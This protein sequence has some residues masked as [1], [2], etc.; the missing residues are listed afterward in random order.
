MIRLRLLALP[1][2]A[3][4][5]ACDAALPANSPQA[6]LHPS[7]ETATREASA[8]A[9]LSALLQEAWDDS[10]REHPIRASTLGDRRWNSLW[11][12]V[13]KEGFERRHQ[14]DE[15][16]LAR[17]RALPR[18]SLSPQ[19][20]LNYDIFERSLSL[21]IEA[22]P[23]GLY[24]LILNPREGIQTRDVLTKTLRFET[25]K[26][27]ED[28]L[29][30]LKAFPAYTDQTIATLREGIRT[31]VVQARVVME[32]VPAQLDKQ[33]VPAEESGFFAPFRKFPG[34]VPAAERDRL[35][36]AAR[37][38]IDAAVVPSF[39]RLREFVV[40]EY[41][42]ACFEQVGAWQ[43]P[44]GAETYVYL[45]R[46]HTTTSLSPQQIH[47][48]GIAEVAR[49]RAEME[50][51]KAKVGF[52][53]SLSEFFTML[54]SDPR[55]FY[56]TKDELFAGYQAIAKRIDP[57]LVK[58]FKKLPRTP[59]GVEPIDPKI[60]PDTTTAYYQPPADDGSRAGSYFVNLYKPE[61]RPKW[62]MMALSLHEAVPGHHLQI[63]LSMEQGAI[64][65]FRRNGWWTAF[66]EGWALYA[67]S[68]GA[69]VGLYDDPYSKFGQLTYEM[70]RAVRLVIDTGI[71][72]LRWDRKK[73]I[74]YFMANAAK[75]ELDVT[76]EVDRYISMPG[77]ALAYKV[78]EL[79]I[80]ELRARAERALGARFDLR[81]FHDAVL[82][83]GAVP[84]DILERHVDEWI[85]KRAK[86]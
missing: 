29:A 49:I 56:K 17:L 62:E 64:P 39:R 34:A 79:K 3:A 16:F 13:S 31:R 73:A 67:E 11:G 83:Q 86:G 1:L 44:Q 58:L 10:L 35:A 21:S 85:A 66:G 38:A 18:A 12:D 4:F 53:G 2:L 71:H 54:R 7:T 50:A 59:Y 70:W 60:A 27:Y 57:T 76:N 82:E 65:A 63:A 61:A 47:E 19:Q 20:Q 42:P 41:L 6:A 46:F 40:K 32:R 23:Y 48:K 74:D 37:E 51:I 77:Q 78:G 36:R 22:F 55:F 72:A 24:R 15:A 25:L 8:D 69:E 5:T 81:E 30:R 33:I 45:T 43:L 80:K 52:S 75:Q 68:L 9:A 84:L 14:H 26:D 28:W